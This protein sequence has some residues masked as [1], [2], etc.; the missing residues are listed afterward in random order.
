V[1]KSKANEERG[2]VG[3]EVLVI[4]EKLRRP[5]WIERRGRGR[6]G[7]SGMILSLIQRAR[8]AGRT[9]KPLDADYKSQTLSTYYPPKD[10][11][12][13]PNPYGASQP[14]TTDITG[15]KTWMLNELNALL[16]DGIPRALDSSGGGSE[17]DEM[18]ADLDIAAFCRDFGISLLSVCML[19]PDREDFKHLMEAVTAK[20]IR[21]ENL[22]IVFNEATLRGNNPVIGFGP[23][24][25]SEDFKSLKK[26]GTNAMF[27]HRL[28]CMTELREAREDFYVVASG[29]RA[30]GTRPLATQVHMTRKWIEQNESEFKR[31]EILDRLP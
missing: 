28:P 25:E 14:V 19:G 15:F 24:A 29:K 18:M 2:M 4:E 20:S 30:D 5:I 9:V 23:I 21:P 27:M 26:D 13:D 16:E 11:K 17:F 31:L 8:M 3:N 22:L 10:A 6:L 1:S 12:G 7:G